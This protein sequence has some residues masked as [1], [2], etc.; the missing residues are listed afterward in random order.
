MSAITC[1]TCGA[2]LET[3]NRAYSGEW[4]AHRYADDCIAVL[5]AERDH[6][7]AVAF[8]RGV[9]ATRADAGDMTAEQADERAARYEATNR[10]ATLIK[11]A[12]LNAFFAREAATKLRAWAIAEVPRG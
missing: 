1:M 10:P 5:R 8:W 2:P 6:A 4:V 11:A 7:E 9:C 12:R 3:Y